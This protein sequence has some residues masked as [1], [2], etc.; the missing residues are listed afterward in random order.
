MTTA[1]PEDLERRLEDMVM[2][3]R[4]DPLRFAVSMFPWKQPGTA[5]A[6]RMLEKWQIE[7]LTEL[8]NRIR[9]PMASSGVPVRM[10]GTMA[11]G[12]GK[13]A[14]GAIIK[15][16][17]I[18]TA[19]D[20]RIRVTAGTEPQLRATTWPEL[21]KWHAMCLCG[22]WFKLVG[23]Q[24]YQP[25]RSANWRA[26][27]MPW[28]EANPDAFAGLHNQGKRLLV[29]TDEASTV[30]DVIAERLQSTMTDIDTEMIWIA[31][32]NPTTNKGWFARLF[33]TAEG[34]NWYLRQLDS[35]EVSLTNQDYAK[36]LIEAYGEDSDYVRVYIRGLFPKQDHGQFIGPAMVDAAMEREP[37]S[38]TADPLV[39]GADIGR[40]GDPS[41]FYPRRGRDARSIE[42]L[43][44]RPT[45]NILDTD[46]VQT[47]ARLAQFA[48][49]L[50]ADG[51][52]VDVGGM[53]VGVYDNVTRMGLN[54]P[55]FPV[56][57]GSS[58]DYALDQTIRCFNKR[59]EIWASVRSWL[60]RGAIRKSDQLKAELTG[61]EHEYPKGKLLLE[62][63]KHM[64]SR[65][66]F[67]PN[68]ADALALTFAYPVA[69]K[70]R[71]Q[72]YVPP[73]EPRAHDTMAE[74]WDRPPLEESWPRA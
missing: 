17:A 57:F 67:S 40:S 19:P 26:D 47:A 41:V 64:R 62:E 49:D 8:G 39:I 50:K 46:T 5:L 65:L 51:I 69:S 27:A 10:A 53:G 29:E 28:S 2:L 1:P 43:V 23:G 13:T 20:T 33:Q 37:I 42:P 3:C 36:E 74:R 30:A 22:H 59:A 73:E 72:D 21:A 4:H 18:A 7:W 24:L 66:G 63:K 44:L 48:R 61:P 68:E 11:K 38:T 71:P 35:R 32:G 9:S 25:D 55:I 60:S 54:C 15:L 56:D 34:R 70:F 58:P 16:W 12:V 31:W 14:L 6:D 45:G 52:C